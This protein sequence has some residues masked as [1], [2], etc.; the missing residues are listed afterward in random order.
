[1]N[2][3]LF[4]N[5]FLSYLLLVAVFVAVSGIAVFIGITLRK[6]ANKKAAAAAENTTEPGDTNEI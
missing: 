5:S 4:L 3:V 2:A 6:R 1:M